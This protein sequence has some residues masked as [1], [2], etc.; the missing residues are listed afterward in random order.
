MATAI[1]RP[2]AHIDY[3][4][5]SY[6]VVN[7]QNAYDNNENTFC[8]GRASGN[9]FVVFKSFDMT[10]IPK[11]ISHITGITVCVLAKNSATIEANV[12]HSATTT[13]NFVDCGDGVKTI[14]TIPK[15]NLQEYT[16]VFPYSVSYWNA[17]LN[18]FLN[19]D[20]QIRM[21]GIEKYSDGPREIYIRVDYEIKTIAVTTQ[22]SPA[23]G[24]T[25][26]GGGT[27]ES[28][29]TVTVTATPNEG[30][31]FSHW[32]VNGADSGV[33]TPTISGILTAD[34][35]V[36]A[37]FVKA[38]EPSKIHLG[39]QKVSVYCGTKKVSVYCG[40]KKLI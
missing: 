4:N 10:A 40:T 12:C 7:A 38:E 14:K 36:T 32:L 6:G 20:I 3:S 28:G 15:V 37:V 31:V 35:T 23:E 16:G 19:G 33:T 9:Q 34:T 21:K 18:G 39:T 11:S 2:T 24:G 13:H 17:N 29:S 25:V 27:Y 1:I 5:T 30:Y 8:Y 22:S 26:T